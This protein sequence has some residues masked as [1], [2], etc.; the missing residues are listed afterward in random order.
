MQLGFNLSFSRVHED[1]KEEIVALSA[2]SRDACNFLSG[3][4][5]PSVVFIQVICERGRALVSFNLSKEVAQA[6]L[7]L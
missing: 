3:W 1:S 6:G 2:T 4:D 5:A 7:F